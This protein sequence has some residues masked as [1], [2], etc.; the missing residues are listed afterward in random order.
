[1]SFLT[2]LP[3]ERYDAQAFDDFT[4]TRDFDLGDGKAL[5]WMSQLAYETDE[6]EKIERILSRWGM[7][8]VEGGLL[9]KEVKSFLPIAKTCGIIAAGRGV[10]I[11]AFA[12]TDPLVLANWITDF[13]A[14]LGPKGIAEGYQAAAECVW[15]A[16]ANLLKRRASNETK[17][18]LTGHS[19]GGALAVLTALRINAETISDVESIY[20]FGMPRPGSSDFSKQYNLRLGPRTFR[21]VHGEDLV[22]TVAPSF[23]GF[24]H[25]G[26]YLHRDRD[27]KF[28]SNALAANT[29]SDDPPFVAG[30]TK[31]LISLMHSPLSRTLSFVQRLKL[32]ALMT[33]GRAPSDLRTDPGGIAIEM[34]PPRLRDH[35]PD[36]YIGGF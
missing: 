18:Y 14:E 7:R 33:T 5:A 13:D 17:V 26:R 27:K 24:K 20:T 1:M 3:E 35:M 16:L 12:G 21:L 28:D 15:P 30:V 34:L 2:K 11:V 36:R 32:A 29:D 6:P 4:A 25:V 22:S 31:D 10:T 19:L 9:L 8:L 23:L